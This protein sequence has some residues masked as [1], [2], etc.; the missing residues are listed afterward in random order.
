M[1]FKRDSV[2]SVIKTEEKNQSPMPAILVYRP[3]MS[4]T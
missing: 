1:P 4:W 2:H 3:Q